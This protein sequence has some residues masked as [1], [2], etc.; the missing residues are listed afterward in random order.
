MYFAHTSLTDL[1]IWD[2]ELKTY[3]EVAGKEI[4]SGNIEKVTT[5]EKAKFPQ[6]FFPECKWSRKGF[7]RTR[8]CIRGTAVE[9][10]NIHLFHDASNLLAMEPYPSVYCRSRRRALRHTLRHVHSDLHAAPY[11]IFGDFNFRTDT[12]GVVKV[13]ARRGAI[14]YCCRNQ[15]GCSCSIRTP[16]DPAR[17]GI[18]IH[19]GSRWPTPQTAAAGECRHQTAALLGRAHRRGRDNRVTDSEGSPIR[20]K[21]VRN[22]SEGSPKPGDAL[23]AELRRLVD[24]PARKRNEYGVI[25]DTACMGDHKPIYLRVM[26]QSDRGTLDCCDTILP[27]SICVNATRFPSTLPLTF[28]HYTPLMPRLRRLPTDPDLLSNKKLKLPDISGS[29]PDKLLSDDNR[30][31]RTRTGSLNEKILRIPHVEITRADYCS[32]DRIYV[33]DVDNTLLTVRQCVD[34]YTPESIDSHS[35]NVEASSGSDITDLGD[36]LG[37]IDLKST[38]V[39]RDRSVSPTLLKNRLDKLL[40]DKEKSIPELQRLD[41]RES[42]GSDGSKKGGLCCLALKCYGFCRRRARKVK[43]E[44]SGLTKCC[45]S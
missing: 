45:T 7:L 5:K 42:C 44:C 6:H 10:I 16:P 2:F 41:S 32:Y 24:A 20:R 15:R 8:W 18:C 26:L 31:K 21:L 1:K 37:E 4:H 17:T 36:D 3:V 34:P 13:Y 38:K 9:F 23:S 28:P 14:G 25:G 19:P 33:N 43:C 30:M 39:N 40:S 22:Q 11:F 27:C 12:G 35:P 29:H